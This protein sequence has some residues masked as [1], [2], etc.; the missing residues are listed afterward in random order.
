MAEEKKDIKSFQQIEHEAEEQLNT[1]IF[2]VFIPNPMTHSVRL[3]IDGGEHE[4]Y[5]NIERFLEVMSHICEMKEVNKI[6]M[7]CN[8]YGTPFLYDRQNSKL[9][10]LRE[11]PPARNV[12]FTADYHK[13]YEGQSNDPHSMDNY[14]NAAKKASQGINNFGLPNFDP[15]NIKLT[16]I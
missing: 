6:S 10:Q 12:E 3:W 13:Q 4:T 9:K 16:K 1:F 15:T 14:F 5:M 2:I 11:L 7:A 8:E